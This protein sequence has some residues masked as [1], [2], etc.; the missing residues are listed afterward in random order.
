MEVEK[1]LRRRIKV[2]ETSKGLI[3]WEH[4]IDGEN[5]TKEELLEMSDDMTEELKKRYPVQEG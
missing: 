4:T 3:S 5:F 1:K 2:S